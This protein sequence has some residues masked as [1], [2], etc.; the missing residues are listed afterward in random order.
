M[1]LQYLSNENL[2]MDFLQG[3]VTQSY[4]G[5][6]AHIGYDR[7][8]YAEVL[9]RKLTNTLLFFKNKVIPLKLAVVE[10][11]EAKLTFDVNDMKYIHLETC[12][13]PNGLDSFLTEI[14]NRFINNA[15]IVERYALGFPGDNMFFI[16]L[17]PMT[18][19]DMKN[20]FLLGVPELDYVI[21]KV[22][23]SKNRE[24]LKY[25][26]KEKLLI[27]PGNYIERKAFDQMFKQG[28]LAVDELILSVTFFAKSLVQKYRTN[29]D[30]EKS[31]AFI[32][33]FLSKVLITQ[34]RKV[35]TTYLRDLEQGKIILKTKDHVLYV[36]SDLYKKYLE[37]N[38]ED[39]N[40]IDALLG[41][42]VRNMNSNPDTKKTEIY[43]LKDII[44]QKESLAEEYVGF[45]QR[46]S[47][48]LHE[49]KMGNLR[50]YYL[51]TLEEQL[52]NVPE[53]DLQMGKEV[54][55]TEEIPEYLRRTKEYLDT[56][57]DYE[58]K[59]V[60]NTV[61][62]IVGNIIYHNDYFTLFAEELNKAKENYEDISIEQA[63]YIAT[64]NL[65]IEFLSR[66]ICFGTLEP[67]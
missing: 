63:C 25:F 41:V 30:T 8:R 37:E 55:Y 56:L 65:V 54:S 32:N 1:F 5:S 26:I 11:I 59:N 22:L 61:T 48:R 7:N 67:K 16:D 52:G 33:T 18:E 31:E 19:E 9:G 20:L 17:D 2:E 39:P 64:V 24:D 58:L 29:L 44:P 28:I 42:Y 43:F 6:Y 46:A 34:L 53:E 23:I 40:T 62:H 15:A 14:E 21:E 3:S 10:G 13:L 66:D 35:I 4:A 12:E 60:D 57:K 27:V 45:T 38:Q 50:K 47:I 51:Q 36:H 49:Q